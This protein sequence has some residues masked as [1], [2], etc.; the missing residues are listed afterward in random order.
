MSWQLVTAMHD[1]GD[2]LILYECHSHS[3]VLIL[4]LLV[5]VLLVPLW[6]FLCNLIDVSP[7]WPLIFFLTGLQVGE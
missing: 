3:Y 4:F 5:L 2:G 7:F 1:E 6:I